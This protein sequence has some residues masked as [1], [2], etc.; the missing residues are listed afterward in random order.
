[1]LLNSSAAIFVV[2]VFFPFSSEL[3]IYFFSFLYSSVCEYV[4]GIMV[5]MLNVI[6]KCF[7]PSLK[8]TSVGINVF[9]P[10]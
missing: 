7:Y 8:G 10:Q 1:M 9:I 5:T 6:C 3:L 4:K 2:F